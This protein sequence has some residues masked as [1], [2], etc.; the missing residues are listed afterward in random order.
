MSNKDVLMHVD[1]LGDLY[2]C[3][4]LL[5]FIYPRVFLCKDLF[6]SKY[7]FYEM[8]SDLYKDVWLVTRISGAEYQ[9]LVL[10][11]KS[12]QDAYIDKSRD[13]LFSITK[14]YKEE[15]DE[16]K[17]SLKTE[18]WMEKLPVNPIFS[19]KEISDCNISIGT[20]PLEL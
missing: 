18:E 3:D 1:E 19:E 7:L 14:I 9:D 20:S 4:V 11:N 12:I 10:K 17:L 15:G 8:S 2:L 5:D 16:I 13:D 6:D